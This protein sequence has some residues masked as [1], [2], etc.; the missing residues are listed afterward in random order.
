LSPSDRSSPVT[1]YV[2]PFPAT[3]AIYQISETTNG[4]HQFWSRD[5]KQL[6]YT[7]GPGRRFVVSV[8]ATPNFTLANRVEIPGLE[9]MLGNPPLMP[10]NYDSTPDGKLF[11]V[12]RSGR[13]GLALANTTTVQVVLNWFE[14]LKARVPTK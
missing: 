10:R 5:G 9:A 1:A 2:Q 11:G 3:G 14:E 12:A 13:S 4:F 8:T 6:F 7:A